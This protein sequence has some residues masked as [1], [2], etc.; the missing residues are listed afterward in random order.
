MRK[1]D[2]PIQL[3]E[4][5][6]LELQNIVRKGQHKVTSKPVAMFRHLSECR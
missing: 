4:I 5:E 3:S 6:R 2:H 1:Q